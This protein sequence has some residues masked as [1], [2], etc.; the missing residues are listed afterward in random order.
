VPNG[1][2][3]QKFPAAEEYIKN[4]L[5]FFGAMNYF[6]NIDG[7]LYFHEQIL[8]LIKNRV[9]DVQ[10]TIAGMSP[11][12][13]I[14]KL[15]GENVIVTGYVPDIRN[16]VA[17]ASVCVV[18]LRIAKGMQNKVLEAMAMEVPVVATTAANRGIEAR[19]KKEILLADTPAEF[20]KATLALLRD[21]GLHKEIAANAKQFVLKNFSWDTHLKK[22]NDVIVRVMASS[23]R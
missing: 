9:P 14:R 23:T 13:K 2:D 11:V 1:I 16:Y 18:P 22:L 7:V 15:S 5:V 19:D 21:V 6:A 3:F 4:S 8:P 20:A 17:Q 12:R 10:F